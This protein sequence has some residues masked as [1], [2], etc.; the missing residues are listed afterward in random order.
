MHAHSVCNL[1]LHLII[2]FKMYEPSNVFPEYMHINPQQNNVELNL[3]AHR[4]S[5]DRVNSNVPKKRRWLKINC[6]ITLCHRTKKKPHF[7]LNR[8]K[9]CIWQN[10]QPLYSKNFKPISDS[11]KLS[12]CF[13]LRI[14]PKSLVIRC[15]GKVWNVFPPRL[16]TKKGRLPSSYTLTR[17]LSSKNR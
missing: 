12:Q 16:G 5:Y 11:R 8:H 6:R 10:Q 1:T 9:K 3:V 14:Y 7:D 13:N 17:Q 2:T 4:K 15:K